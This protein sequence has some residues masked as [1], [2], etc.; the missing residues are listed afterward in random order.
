MI[1]A[2]L[3]GDAERFYRTEIEARRR[4][5]MP[6]FGRLAALIVSATDKALAETHARALARAAHAETGTDALDA[7]EAP[8]I[9]VFGAGR[10][11][12]RDDPRPLPLSGCW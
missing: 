7:A 2:L 9:E 10:G 4:A 1:R 6:P 3:D 8:P 11:A 12:G 5:A